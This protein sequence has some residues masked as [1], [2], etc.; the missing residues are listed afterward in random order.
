[1]IV[2][3]NNAY[4]DKNACK[5]LLLIDHPFDSAPRE[6]LICFIGE[7]LLKVL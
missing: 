5:F 2:F 1:V 6:G 3:A 4:I 7:M